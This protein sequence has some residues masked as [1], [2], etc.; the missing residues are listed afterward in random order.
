MLLNIKN[1]GFPTLLETLGVQQPLAGP[2]WGFESTVIPTFQIGN[3]SVNLNGG[4]PYRPA[5]SIDAV[6]VNP[7]A[8]AALIQ[9]ASLEAGRYAFK[10]NWTFINADVANSAILFK[11]VAVG[12]AVLRTTA[13][14]VI[15]EIA[16]NRAIG[17]GQDN[18]VEDLNNLDFIFVENLNALA[19]AELRLTLRWNRVAPLIF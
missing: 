17:S 1:Q 9:T 4:L 18:F 7:L 13:V 3:S 2:F 16:T 12:G 6:A 15:G 11:V 5:D 14:D 10:L 19:A 8:S